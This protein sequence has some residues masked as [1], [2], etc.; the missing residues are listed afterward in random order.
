MSNKNNAPKNNAPKN[1][2]AKGNATGANQAPT[3]NPPAINN[4]PNNNSNTVNIAMELGKQVRPQLSKKIFILLIIIAGFFGIIALL[5][6]NTIKRIDVLHNKTLGLF[7]KVEKKIGM[8]NIVPNEDMK[9]TYVLYLNVDNS[10]GNEAWYSSY[11]MHKYI[12]WRQD[13]SFSIK[14]SPSKNK[15]IISTRVATL[16]VKGSGTGSQGSELELGLHSKYNDFEVPYIPLQTWFQLVVMINNRT[17]DVYMNKLLVR[18]FILDNVPKLSN[19]AII[20][21]KKNHNP[22]LYIG[23]LEHIPSLIT[24]NEIAA[25]YFKNMRGLSVSDKHRKEIKKANHDHISSFYG[26]SVSN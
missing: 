1:N 2:A 8:E 18:T 20:L 5:F 14:Y 3:A 26:P 9:E 10:H 6:Y 7:N 15:I 21:G 17:I 24:V 16:S 19:E 11:H 22:N 12:M 25:L 23:R 4:I 13:E